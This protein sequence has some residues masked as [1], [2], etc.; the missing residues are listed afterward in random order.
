MSDSIPP[1]PPVQPPLP[2]APTPSGGSGAKLAIIIVACVVGGFVAI[3]LL[4]AVM[5][6]P[7]LN[8]ARGL[9]RKAACMANL[10]GIGKSVVLYSEIQRG[11]YPLIHLAERAP[12][13]ANSAPTSANTTD[14]EPDSGQWPEVMG[15]SAMQNVWLLIHESLIVESG[16]RCPADIESQKRLVVDPRAAKYGWNSPFNYSYGMQW[17]YETDAAGKANSA[18]LSDALDGRMVIFADRNPG[19]PVG[20][21]RRPSNHPKLGTGVLLASGTVE[22]ID[23]GS[24][25]FTTKYARRLPLAPEEIYANGDG[26]PGALPTSATDTSICLSGR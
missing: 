25:V 21:T 3:V 15:D 23:K 7:N 8:R 22:W 26:A 12:N 19:G 4:L 9:A 1:A 14:A 20:A 18:P 10:N 17:P 5:L 2:E 16:F 11:Q 24:S 13:G 6:M